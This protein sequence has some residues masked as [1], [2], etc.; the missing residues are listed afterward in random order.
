MA[1]A[2]VLVAA[3]CASSPELERQRE[4]KAADIAEILSVR[5]DPT[6]FGESRRCLGDHEYRSFRPLDDS[7]MLFE[8]RGDKLW[9]NTLRSRCMDLNHGDV[10]IV[11]SFSAT[12]MCDAD[13]FEATD[14]FHWPWYRRTP[15]HSSVHW[16]SGPTCV[17]GSFQPITKAQV[18]EIEAIIRAD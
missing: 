6:E 18:A 3:G 9:I 17:L 11:H 14:W 4:A 16:G 1:M 13:K 10:Y 2:T 12:Q 7:H 8:G 15:W 5:L